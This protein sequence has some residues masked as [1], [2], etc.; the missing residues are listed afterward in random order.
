MMRT[1]NLVLEV[2]RPRVGLEFGEGRERV[3]FV[4]LVHSSKQPPQLRNYRKHE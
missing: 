4:P 3:L 2:V 1:M